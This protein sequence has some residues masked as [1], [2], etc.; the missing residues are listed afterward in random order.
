M[1]TFSNIKLHK[2]EDNLIMIPN[3]NSVSPLVIRDPAGNYL[4]NPRFIKSQD[5]NELK[6]E[7][8]MTDDDGDITTFIMRKESRFFIT[9]KFFFLKDGSNAISSI[10]SAK[11]KLNDVTYDMAFF[12]D[13]NYYYIHL[14]TYGLSS[15]LHSGPLADSVDFKDKTL[16]VIV[17]YTSFDGATLK[18]QTQS[19][20]EKVTYDNTA[21]VLE[22]LGEPEIFLELGTAYNEPGVF[23][24][25]EF[26]GSVAVTSNI[27]DF[28]FTTVG[29]YTITYEAV[30]TAG[31]I[32]IPVERIVNVEENNLQIDIE[33]VSDSKYITIQVNTAEARQGLDSMF[34]TLN[35]SLALEQQE[36]WKNS[37]HI[38]QASGQYYTTLPKANTEYEINWQTDFDVNSNV[39]TFI[40]GWN[41]NSIELGTPNFLIDIGDDL[42]EK[43]EFVTENCT[44]STA[45][46]YDVR[47]K[48]N[49]KLCNQNGNEINN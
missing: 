38:E 13:E 15:N 28:D 4:I 35:M 45:D 30:D 5:Q 33:F 16:E 11:I 10:K 22:L 8:Q 48:Y 6:L 23:A 40:N 32:A 12:Q 21:P 31:N 42:N 9:L 49:D 14:L 44:I 36:L 1:N 2:N 29:R 20:I 46:G 24:N 19:L 17:E 43:I 7:F 25:D 47:I 37:H 41:I 27:D 18:T 26:D 34:I 39:F 3:G